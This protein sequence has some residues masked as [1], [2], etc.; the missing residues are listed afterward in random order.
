[1]EINMQLSPLEPGGTAHA[2][3]DTDVW[4]L[5]AAVVTRS[6]E[7]ELA[8]SEGLLDETPFALA[9]IDGV[10][11]TILEANRA[12]DRLLG[13]TPGAAIPF[14]EVVA[15]DGVELQRRLVQIEWY[16]SIQ[17][18]FR[19]RA[20]AD[21]DYP[22]QAWACRVKT[23]GRP[24]VYCA[25]MR[26]AGDGNAEREARRSPGPDASLEEVRCLRQSEQQAR[27]RA[28]ELEAA[29]VNL[30]LADRRKD[31]FLAQLAHEMRN[32]LAP[33]Q[34]WTQ[35]LLDSEDPSPLV[36]QASQVLARQVRHLTRLVEDLLEVSRF[37]RDKLALKQEP[38][39]LTEAIELAVQMVKPLI[40]ERQ[41][42][43][44]VSLDASPLWVRGDLARL[45]EVFHN[46]LDNAAKY[47]PAGGHIHL[48]VGGHA[49]EAVV[50]V[51][52]DGIGIDPEFL[53]R[54]FDLFARS[55]RAELLPTRGLGL[56]LSLVQQMVRA[57][58]GTIVARS[59]G[60]G[61]GSQFEVRLPLAPPPSPQ[62]RT[63]EPDPLRSACY[64]IL[65]VDDQR[66]TG[67]ALAMYLA[68]RGHDLQ[69][70]SDAASALALAAGF[71]PHFILL[72]I[73]MPGTDGHELARCLRA[74]EVDRR[75]VLIAV[76][77]F[78]SPD[79]RRRALEAGCDDHLPKP[80]D[81]ARLLAVL[82]AHRP[83][84]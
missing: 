15:D 40:D 37:V 44:T 9:V 70:A 84:D 71:R 1:M 77:G 20:P 66:D 47:T 8:L 14:S 39:A 12:A 19:S 72:D 10:H 29:T 74:Q 30:S 35:R 81:P 17:F 38:C 16:E 82:A 63:P 79:D 83:E 57:H 42:Q 28:A 31:E 50:E 33:I 78:T 80:V 56:G 6:C 46:L 59:P 51:D 4:P 48:H 43:L 76:S 45:G 27:A 21:A 54:V 25:F 73:G 22:I 65:V 3:T 26:P 36:R 23:R 13:L 41:Q 32:P 61:L 58:G 69:V 5:A 18:A 52:D 67:E 34:V 53:P 75:P 68:D 55:P 7:P 11:G 60:A 49:G 64:R 62:E 24:L 2:P